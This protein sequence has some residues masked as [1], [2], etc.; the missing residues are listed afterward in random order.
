MKPVDDV[1]EQMQEVYKAH[2]SSKVRVIHDGFKVVRK[3]VLDEV[4]EIVDV[5][6]IRSRLTAHMTE[7]YEILQQAR[8]TTSKYTKRGIDVATAYHKDTLAP[9]IEESIRATYKG[10]K[11]PKNFSLFV[12]LRRYDSC[13]VLHV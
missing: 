2:L 1:M 5:E 10:I 4:N 12:S 6:M 11:T 3:V 13:C 8:K 7:G 9:A